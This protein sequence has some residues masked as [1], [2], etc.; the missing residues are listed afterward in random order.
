MNPISDIQREQLSAY[1]D[2]ALPDRERLAVEQ[3]LQAD[4]A[5]AA[6]LREL[7][8]TVAMLR[9]MPPVRAPRSFTLDPAT[10]APRRSWAFGWQRW[11]TVLGM[12]VLMATVGLN[13]ALGERTLTTAATSAPAANRSDLSEPMADSAAAATAAPAAAAEAPPPAAPTEALAAGAAAPAAAATTAPAADLAQPV[14]ATGSAKLLATTVPYPVP[15]TAGGAA[16]ANG[17]AA[18]TMDTAG[19]AQFTQ[20]SSIATPSN[21]NEMGGLTLAPLDNTDTSSPDTRELTQ[22]QQLAAPAPVADPNA[23][24]VAADESPVLWLLFVVALLLG[25]VG[26]VAVTLAVR[27]LDKR[28]R[29]E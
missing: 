27:R 16:Q 7:Q 9:D 25:I 17:T 3:Q 24:M 10:V 18:P 15:L 14:P 6:E 13:L 28:N 21:E 19:A 12:L 4:S 20:E 23:N 29:N 26:A 22:D 8:T 11:A 2:G 5:L 1:V